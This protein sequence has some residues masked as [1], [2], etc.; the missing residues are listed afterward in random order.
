MTAIK[1]VFP[2]YEITADGKV[3]HL[4]DLHPLEPN[5]FRLLP[6]LGSIQETVYKDLPYF[7]LDLMPSGFLGRLVPRTHR[8]LGLPSNIQLW[9]V[10]QGFAFWSFF[11]WNLVGNLIIGQKA[12]N[13]YLEKRNSPSPAVPQPKLTWHFPILADQIQREGDEGTSA[14]GEQPKFLID[15][16]QIHKS[17]LVKFS[18]PIVDATSQRVADLLIAEHVAHQVLSEAGIPA[19]RSEIIRVKNQVFLEIERFDRNEAQGRRGIISL[20]ALE[21]EYGGSFNR[22]TETSSRLLKLGKI[23][24]HTDLTIQELEIF[25]TLIG[26]SEMDATNLSFYFDRL[27]LGKLAPV[28]DMVPMSYYP[29]QNQ[30]IPLELK[31]ELPNPSQGK[32]WNL[33]C[34]NAI[35][36]WHRTASHPDVSESFKN[37]AAENHL[38]LVTQKNTFEKLG[39]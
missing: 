23:D 15:Y 5:G 9:S 33:A 2:L 20:Q 21:T 35:E 18:P 34:R 29:Q 3:L 27:Q 31:V 30:L 10:E 24:Q 36:F 1:G 32:L 28:Y 4:A 39:A 6:K 13:H 17:S 26:N 12:L 22:W 11:G 7:L 19:A 38:T 37:I 25:G 16:R 14:S 8:E